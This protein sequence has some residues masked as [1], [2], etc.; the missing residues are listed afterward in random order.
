MSEEWGSDRPS[1][2]RPSFRGRE[3]VCS[4]SV[5]QSVALHRWVPMSSPLYPTGRQKHAR[6]G[7]TDDITLDRDYNFDDVVMAASC[8]TFPYRQNISRGVSYRS[9]HPTG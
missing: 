9:G 5:C 6:Q 7:G 2:D 1:F 4:Q 3:R 8:I